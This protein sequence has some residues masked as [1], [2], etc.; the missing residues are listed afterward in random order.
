MMARVKEMKGG[1]EGGAA[2]LANIATRR[3]PDRAMAKRV[4][5]IVMAAAPGLSPRLWYGMP[6]YEKDDKGGCFFQDANK[7]KA[8]YATLGFSDKAELG[9]APMCPT[10]SALRELNAGVEAAITALVRRAV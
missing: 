5:A 6:A 8:R 7:F 3:E 4:H 10:A 9:G 2:V 1:G